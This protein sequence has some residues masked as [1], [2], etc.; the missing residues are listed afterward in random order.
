MTLG[1]VVIPSGATEGRG[2]GITWFGV[3]TGNTERAAGAVD[4]TSV[5]SFEASRTDSLSAEL[6]DLLRFCGSVAAADLALRDKRLMLTL[7]ASIIIPS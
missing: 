1:W 7:F 3:T 5:L 4:E 6:D 2:L